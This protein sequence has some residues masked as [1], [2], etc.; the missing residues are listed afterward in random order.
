MTYMLELLSILMVHAPLRMLVHL[1]VL[2]LRGKWW[3]G[4]M[5]SCYQI[6]LKKKKQFNIEFYYLTSQR[7]LCLSH[8]IRDN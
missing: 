3:W 2:H 6:L 1:V 4:M 7:F 5:W 8:I